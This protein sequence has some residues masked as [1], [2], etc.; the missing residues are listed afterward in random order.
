LITK[1]LYATHFT[2]LPFHW[3]HDFNQAEGYQSTTGELEG[4]SVNFQSG[5]S[6]GFTEIPVEM[7]HLHRE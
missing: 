4:F 2:L 5:F 1:N 7:N 6:R 3:I